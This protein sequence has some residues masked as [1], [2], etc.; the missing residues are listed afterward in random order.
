MIKISR[1]T[2]YAIVILSQMVR[3]DQ[4]V[5]SASELAEKSRLPLPT[6]SKI[7]KKLTKNNI[8]VAQR[9]AMGGYKLQF[10]A[11]RLSVAAI[12]EAMDGPIAVTDCA[13]HPVIEVC[14]IESICPMRTN[15]NRVNRVLRKALEEVSLADMLNGDMAR[16]DGTMTSQ[17]A[18]AEKRL[19]RA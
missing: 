6:T 1:L 16:V 15:W 11:Q 3:D 10:S 4:P 19:Q 5:F 18:S 2:D 7:L 14:R 8:V 13:N 17:T 12:I 9:G